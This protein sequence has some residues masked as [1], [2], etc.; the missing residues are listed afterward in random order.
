ML[1]MDM[2]GVRTLTIINNACKLIEKKS[3][4][5]NKYRQDP[6]DDEKLT[7]CSNR[8]IRSP[9]SSWNPAECRDLRRRFELSPSNTSRH[10]GRSTVGSDGLIPFFINRATAK[11]KIE[12]LHR[13]WRMSARELMAS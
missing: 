8:G 1:K 6:S 2:L 10:G 4:S 5:H 3:W 12:Y 9:S 7:P 13:F 11:Y